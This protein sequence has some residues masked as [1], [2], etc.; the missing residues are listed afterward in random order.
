MVVGFATL[1]GN[2]NVLIFFTSGSSG[3]FNIFTVILSLTF[4]I[5][6]Q[7]QPFE[8]ENKAQHIAIGNT[9]NLTVGIN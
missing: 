4:I 3:V 6:F 7:Q 8:K 2:G 5:E 9:V 1:F